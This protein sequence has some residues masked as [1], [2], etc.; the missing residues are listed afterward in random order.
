[1]YTK[2]DNFS[3]TKQNLFSERE[4]VS[5]QAG[6]SWRSV[7]VNVVIVQPSNLALHKFLF[8]SRSPIFILFDN[9]L[10]FFFSIRNRQ[11]KRYVKR[12]LR[13]PY[14]LYQ[15]SLHLRVTTC[16]IVFDYSKGF[17][18]SQD[19]ISGPMSSISSHW[20]Y[21]CAVWTINL[22]HRIVI[23]PDPW[24]EVA[25]NLD[26]LHIWSLSKVRSNML[27]RFDINFWVAS[28]TISNILRFWL[29]ILC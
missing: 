20:Y 2:W 15:I 19:F 10:L 26:L 23:F 27:F 4:K 22:V 11:R 29:C 5:N 28:W 12:L 7:L 21:M 13:A 6:Q 18:H 16:E 17:L 8:S 14:N 3:Q 24:Y 1:M 25:E 9:F